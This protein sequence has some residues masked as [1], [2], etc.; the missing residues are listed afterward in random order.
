MNHDA[1]VS[2]HM[3]D[4]L[5]NFRP[6]NGRELLFF[7]FHSTRSLIEKKV[8][9]QELLMEYPS[10]LGLAGLLRRNIRRIDTVIGMTRSSPTP[11]H[12]FTAYMDYTYRDEASL[13]IKE[14]ALESDAYPSFR[15]AK[16]WIDENRRRLLKKGNTY[17]GIMEILG[18]GFDSRGFAVEWSVNDKGEVFAFNDFCIGNVALG[19]ADLDDDEDYDEASID[20]LPEVSSIHLPNLF[21]AG[22]IVVRRERHYDS[23]IPKIGLVLQDCNGT[24]PVIGGTYKRFVNPMKVLCANLTDSGC[25][26]GFS[27]VYWNFLKTELFALNVPKEVDILRDIS[28]YFA[29]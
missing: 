14:G 12:Y 3:K 9:Y 10:D 11:D 22:D 27:E 4:Y 21:K 6:L 8:A 24:N 5:R 18:Y 17:C 13:E 20:L 29:K 16:R 7:I 23:S 15:Q 2:C 26:C 25:F 1:F 28:R 19:D